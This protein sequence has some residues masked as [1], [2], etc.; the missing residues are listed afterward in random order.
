MDAPT[1]NCIFL[2]GSKT[3]LAPLKP[4]TVPRLELNA[5]VV[6]A[7]WLSRLNLILAPQLNIIGTHAWSDSMIVL[8]WLNIPHES[9]KIYVSNHV[10][11]VQTLILTF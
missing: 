4:L 5:A 7:R 6:L 8:S 2:L 10:H 11:Q 3:K 1:D 9:F